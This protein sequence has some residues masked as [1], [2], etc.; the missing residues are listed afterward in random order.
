MGELNTIKSRAERLLRGERTPAIVWDNHQ[1]CVREFKALLNSEARDNP[2]LLQAIN[3]AIQEH[4]DLWGK[5]SREAPDMLAA[6]GCPP[7]PQAESVGQQAMAMQQQGMGAPPGAPPTPQPGP[8]QVAQ[9]ETEAPKGKPGPQPKPPGAE[10][11]ANPRM[12]K[13]SEPAKNPMD[14]QPVTG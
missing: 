5:L 13:P 6:I 3:A 2:P 14:G 4:F 8:R 11:G 9:P 7:L 10:P 1:L 12:P